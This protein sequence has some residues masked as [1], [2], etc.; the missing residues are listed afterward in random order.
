MSEQEWH[1]WQNWPGNSVTP[2][3]QCT[4]CPINCCCDVHWI[5]VKWCG[6]TCIGICKQQKW[7]HEMYWVYFHY[8]PNVVISQNIIWQSESQYLVSMPQC[9][10]LLQN[11]T[12]H[13]WHSNLTPVSCLSCQ[14][15]SSCKCVMCHIVRNLIIS[16]GWCHLYLI[17]M[18]TI[19][20]NVH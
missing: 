12:W 6:V 19:R 4:G 10:Q 20:P 18:F 7:C 5:K 11:I 2:T 16:L 13:C 17:L 8:Q 3:V 1:Q 14:L 9:G 15:S